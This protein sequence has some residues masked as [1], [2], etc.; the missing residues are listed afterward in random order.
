MKRNPHSVRQTDSTNDDVLKIARAGEAEGYWL[1]AETQS[2]GKGRSGRIWTSPPGNLYATTLVRLRD[3]DPIAPTLALVSAVALHEVAC[4][5]APN[6][7]FTLKWPND[8]LVGRAKLAGILL[9]RE[10]DAIA[11]GFGVNLAHHPELPDRPA[12]SF[13]TLGAGTPDPDNFLVDL[14]DSFAR[15]LAKWRQAGV[16][17]ISGEWLRRAHEV[18]AA[19][20]VGLPDGRIDGLFDGLDPMGA[21]RL[22]LA[23]GSVR[24]IQ[25][26]D[27]FL[28]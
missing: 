12:T 25:A 13:C 4:A 23:D 15:W 26:G 21:L 2:G 14:A 24:V 1:R 10:G 11:V 19:L 27:V 6:V 22:R 7:R 5:Y 16:A 18:G 17:P 20:S 28:L 3:G 8:M 9:E